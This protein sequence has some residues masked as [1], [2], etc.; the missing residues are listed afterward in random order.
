LFIPG[1]R[2]MTRWLGCTAMAVLAVGLAVRA[3]NGT[4]KKPD[5]KPDNKVAKAFDDLQAELKSELNTA[6][7]DA[8]KR[9]AVFAKFSPKFLDHAKKNAKDDSAV[10]ALEAV[11]QM[12]SAKDKVKAREEAIELLKK[13]YVKTL[14]IGLILRTLASL[15]AGTSSDEAS[16]EIVKAVAKDNPDKLIRA[17]ALDELA[18]SLEFRSLVAANLLR[19]EKLRAEYEKRLGEE[20]VRK[21]VDSGDDSRKEAA[22]LRKTIKADYSDVLALED[23]I[24]G[25]DLKVGAKAPDTQG[26]D[27]YGKQ[28]KLSDLKGKV[29]VLDFWA[30]W[31]GPCR[32]M[33]PHTRDLVKENEKKPFVFISVSCDA[34]R[35][36][37]ED[38]VQ[39]NDMPWT[40][41][42]DGQGGKVSRTYE[43]GAF[44]T[45]Y[46]VDHKGVLQFKS[47]GFDKKLDSVVE[48]LVKEAEADKK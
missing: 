17:T 8:E 23:E 16:L 41:W 26:E 48:K 19:N 2:A 25:S 6:G 47:V 37:L 15:G 4:N 39:K 22:G 21:L 28:V 13:D 3:D 45:I 42:W 11:L 30:T 29:V 9:K 46:V 24:K 20:F 27:I 1:E 33:I 32:A 43:I 18:G 36:T 38:F 5:K 10:F 12:S 34:K 31:C 7:K 14:Q 40:H 44:P 35:E